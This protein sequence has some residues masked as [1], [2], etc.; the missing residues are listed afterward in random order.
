M[1]RMLA[2]G[3]WLILKKSIISFCLG[4]MFIAVTGLGAAS[5]RDLIILATPEEPYKFQED[6]VYKGID[7]DIVREAMRRLGIPFSIEL[8]QSG[9]RIQQEAR[10]G[11]ADML[12]LF[13]KKLD[14]ME[15]L[16]YP[17]QT[18]VDISWNFF[19]RAEDESKIKY[20]NFDDLRGYQIGITQ[21]FSYTPEF[22]NSGLTFQPMP[23]NDL[24]IGKLLARRLDVVP[25]N[26]IST[27]YEE[28]KSGR[29]DAITY[30]PKPLTTKPYYNVFAKASRYP[31]IAGLAA[32][33]DSVIETMKSDGTVDVIIRKYLG[34]DL[35]NDL[36]GSM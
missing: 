34:R 35:N 21:D 32:R 6:G 22:L 20:E 17:E 9:T 18:Y 15:F 5:A 4:S 36:R 30:L 3:R 10:A 11:R 26:T 14:R 8:I 28:K 13:S 1:E 19:I 16:I 24:Q 25:M 33:Y 29:L 23:R 7:I 2:F 31:D 27:L 12:L